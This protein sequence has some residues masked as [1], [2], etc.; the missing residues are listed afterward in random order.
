[1]A[2]PPR[3]G[4]HWF[5]RDL[6]VTGNSALQWSFSK[7]EG[8]VLGIFCFDSKFLSREDFSAIR[9]GFFLN[10]MCELQKELRE[11]GGDLLALDV[12]PDEAFRKLFDQMKAASIPLPHSISFNRDYEPY[13][14]SRDARLERIFATEYGIEVH[15]ERDH[16]IIEP[17]EL[18]REDGSPGAYKVYTPFSRKWLSIF[19][20]GE[21]QDRIAAQRKS[22]GKKSPGKIFDLTW[23]RLLGSKLK[24][25]D[26]LENYREKTLREVSIELPPAGHAAAIKHLQPFHGA[27]LEN[28]GIDRDIPGIRGTSQMSIYLKNGS[29]TTSQIVAEL[30]LK[31]GKPEAS[32]TRYL[33]E[34]VWR[35]FYY[36]VLFHF[37]QV[38]K[39][40]FQEKY[41]SIPW[42]NDRKLFK[43]WCEGKTGFPLV[44]A[45]MRQLNATGWMHNRIRMVVAMFLTKDLMID[46][47]WGENYFMKMLLD[48]DLA[49]NNGGW[50]WAA[51]T[52]C[53]AQPYF[54]VFNPVL[55]SQRFDAEG[56]YI[57]RWVPELKSLSAKTIHEPWKTPHS[58]DYPNPV[59]E[60]SVQSKKAIAL[61]KNH[62]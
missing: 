17:H 59:V 7:N 35:E 14:L 12:G 60:H 38:E 34:I 10:T 31:N 9:F 5:R 25:E 22:L 39:T 42:E 27:K 46:Y 32:A 47:R 15:S 36:H 57:R 3:Y 45:G 16:L 19:E 4:L 26:Q 48:G 43:S 11:L 23:K 1:M 33:K 50:Q 44:D 2:N 24:V 20:G 58:L 6:R 30:N 49:P 28:Y 54:R 13:A 53:D 41:A 29:I 8:R 37:P 18:K 51:S 62:A 40:T 21:V 56:V 55:Q 61:F 52:G